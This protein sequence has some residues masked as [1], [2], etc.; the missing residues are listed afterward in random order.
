MVDSERVMV[1]VRLPRALVRRL[2]HYCIDAE[3]TRQDILARIVEQ[4]LDGAAGERTCQHCGAVA[5]QHPPAGHAFEARRA[6][7]GA[8]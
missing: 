8:R 3:A 6:G 4:F 5:G 2:D 1:Q 7:V